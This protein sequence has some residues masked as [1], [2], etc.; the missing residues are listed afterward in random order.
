MTSG[1]LFKKLFKFEWKRNVWLY[2]ASLFVMFLAFP[3]YLLNCFMNLGK[4]YGWNYV[5]LNQSQIAERNNMLMTFVYD[6]AAK[7]IIL[8]SIAAASALVL[9]SYLHSKSK[10]DFYFSQPYKRSHLFFTGILNGVGV[11]VVPYMINLVIA[12]IVAACYNSASGMLFK[13]LILEAIPLLLSAMLVFLLVLIAMILTG[14]IVFGILG[15]GIVCFYFPC[16][17]GI[18]QMYLS[19]KEIENGYGSVVKGLLHLSPLTSYY[20]L[21]KDSHFYNINR[22]F[23]HVVGN[24][25][26]VILVFLVLNVIFAVLAYVLYQKRKAEYIGNAVTFP[27]ARVIIKVLL[28]IPF[29]LGCAKLI[30][31]RYDAASKGMEI[32]AL[33]IGCLIGCLLMETFLHGSWRE[34]FKSWKKQLVYLVLSIACYGAMLAFVSRCP[35]WNPDYGLSDELQN[36]LDQEIKSGSYVFNNY[37]EYGGREN[38]DAFKTNVKAGKDDSLSIVQYEGSS[39]NCYYIDFVGGVYHLSSNQYYA[40]GPD[41]Y[42]YFEL[43]DN[44][45]DAV[46]VLSNQ[47]LTYEQLTEETKDKETQK[48]VENSQTIVWFSLD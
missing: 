32:A 14:S 9:F 13:M 8:F 35:D 2:V 45:T 12:M 17:S 40:D 39:L 20:A 42:K 36:E 23:L 43:V 47:K 37:K 30:A 19:G 1:T 46:L 7:E 11:I 24:K 4:Q 27:I 44:G 22:D 10:S 6:S 3:Y 26:S 31:Y 33:V 5:S 28:V 21:A 25:P 15:S 29:S 34:F 41:I 16:I 48:E 38:W 18:F